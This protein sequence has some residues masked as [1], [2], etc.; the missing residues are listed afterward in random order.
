M[1]YI[2]NEIGEEIKPSVASEKPAQ[3][4]IEKIQSRNKNPR[5]KQRGTRKFF[6]FSVQEKH[7]FPCIFKVMILHRW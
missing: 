6:E 5:R 3:R 1:E 4:I 2:E 7:A